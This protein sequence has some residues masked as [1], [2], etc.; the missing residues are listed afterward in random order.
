MGQNFANVPK[1][2]FCT[3]DIGPQHMCGIAS[4]PAVKVPNETLIFIAISAYIDGHRATLTDDD[5]RGLMNCVK[6]LWLDEDGFMDACMFKPRPEWLDIVMAARSMRS[7]KLH[8]YITGLEQSTPARVLIAQQLT[9]RVG[10][11]QAWEHVAEEMGVRVGAPSDAEVAAADGGASSDGDSHQ[12]SKEKEATD[13]KVPAAAEGDIDV[14]TEDPDANKKSQ[15]SAE[16]PP[17]KA[18]A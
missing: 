14:L 17:K 3:V 13:G 7:D 15:A 11:K 1:D 5:I 18:D 8:K 9:P 4:S 16:E 10:Y 6:G 12:E 2:T